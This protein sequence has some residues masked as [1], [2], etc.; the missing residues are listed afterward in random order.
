M[1][2]EVANR[3]SVFNLADRSS[4]HRRLHGY[5]RPQ[6]GE[7]QPRAGPSG[8]AEEGRRPCRAGLRGEGAL[9]VG[10]H[11]GIG[12][13]IAYLSLATIKTPPRSATGLEALAKDVA[14]QL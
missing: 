1:R 6:A 2:L 4:H 14:V 11:V 9:E 8:P 10:V 13:D 3:A 12:D 7:A 5:G